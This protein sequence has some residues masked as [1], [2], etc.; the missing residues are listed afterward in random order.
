MHI[1]ASVGVL[2]VRHL[3]AQRFARTPLGVATVLL[4][5][6][7]TAA[8]AQ[9]PPLETPVYPTADFNSVDM[10]SGAPYFQLTAIS[11]GPEHSRFI[12]T[13]KSS[14][15]KFFPRNAI[16]DTLGGY[17]LGAQSKYRNEGGSWVLRPVYVADFGGAAEEFF[18]IGSTFI[19]VQERGST[20]VLGP[21]SLITYTLADGTVITFDRL[22]HTIDG[23]AIAGSVTKVQYPDGRILTYWYRTATYYSTL[24][25]AMRLVIRR[26]SVTRN[27]GW[28]MKYSYSLNSN[29]TE[30]T[31]SQWWQ[32]VSTT[33][34]NNSVEYCDPM[35]DS[36]ALATQWPTSTHSW[37]TP[38]SGSGG[39][40]TVTD[41]NGA[42]TRFTLDSSNRVVGVKWPSSPTA[43]NV[44]YTYCNNSCYT[45]NGTDTVYY[46]DMVMNVVRNG[47]AWQYMYWP[48]SG[49]SFSTYRSTSPVGGYTS[50]TQVATFAPFTN[51]VSPLISATG[52]DGSSASWNPTSYA[53]RL[54]SYTDSNGVGHVYAYDTRGNVT[55]INSGG[56]TRSAGYPASCSNPITC[57]KPVWL[58]DALGNQTDLT[59]DTLHGGVLKVT[60]PAVEGIRPQTR[61]SYAQRYA[62]IKNASGSYV[63]AATPIWLLVSESYCR[64]SAASGSGC[65]TAGDQVVTTY[66]YGPDSGPNNLLRRGVLVSADGTS[67]RRCSRYDARGNLMSDTTPRANLS[68]CP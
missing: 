28:Q 12:S 17:F 4:A 54:N 6:C 66:D 7:H 2:A 16:R 38:P 65:T 20:V 23:S 41:Q 22:L 18:Y 40:F 35:A 5:L 44:T 39:T 33:A 15:S 26:Q 27:D 13:L 67:L 24:F 8:Q 45:T 53:G 58:R 50:A 9:M 62:W 19:S 30:Q 64:A 46:T 68:S 48:G 55:S 21:G 32:P 43:D 51:F 61:Y 60:S 49:F 1:S 37:S 10:V 42:V 34:I 56:S 14:G 63:R 3:E 25:Q 57:N 11:I 36:C 47:A 31:V 29:P 52:D 59:Y